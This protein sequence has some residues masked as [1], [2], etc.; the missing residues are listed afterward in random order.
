MWLVRQYKIGRWSIAEISGKQA[1]IFSATIGAD[2][3]LG[4]LLTN[5]SIVAGAADEMERSLVEKDSY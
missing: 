3:R 5:L 2:V 1:V 4:E